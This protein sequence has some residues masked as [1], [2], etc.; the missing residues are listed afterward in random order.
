MGNQISGYKQKLTYNEYK[1]VIQHLDD[2]AA[3]K[4]VDIPHVIHE[5]TQMYIRRFVPGFHQMHEAFLSRPAPEQ[6][7]SKRA[8]L[9]RAPEAKGSK[10]IRATRRKSTR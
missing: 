9:R 4:D 8:K 6:K 7:V 3:R 2:L 10:R 1:D 5:A